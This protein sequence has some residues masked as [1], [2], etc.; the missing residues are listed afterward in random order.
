MNQSADQAVPAAHAP[1][2]ATD[3]PHVFLIST[4]ELPAGFAERL[5]TD[6]T[7]VVPRLAAT[8][9]LLRDGE[10]GPE[11]LLL[12]RHARSGFAAGAWVFPGGTVDEGESPETTAVR[13]TWE[14]T[15]IRVTGDLLP[16]A[17]WVTPEPEPRRFDAW[18]FLARVPPEVQMQLSEAEVT[19]A[20]WLLP[21]DAVRRFREGK[22][23]MLPP[24]AHTLRRLA[25]LGSVDEVWEALR[26][27]PVPT[28]L[29][30]MRRHPEGVAIEIPSGE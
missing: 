30:R 25:G 2:H 29:P 23:K 14:E 4:E 10:H 7:P 11:V 16:I 5:E 27:A 19:E 15:G 6:Y 22:M 12:R 17:R 20:C 3:D 26:D 18:F 13:E 8:A 21:E 9:V 1:R 24:T 28:I